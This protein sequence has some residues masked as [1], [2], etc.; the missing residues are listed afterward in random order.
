MP[1]LLLSN[2]ILSLDNIYFIKALTRVGN[3]QRVEMLRSSVDR[4]QKNSVAYKIMSPFQ[5]LA[6]VVSNCYNNVNPSGLGYG[7]Y[8]VHTKALQYRAQ[9]FG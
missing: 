7:I 1:T 6:V 4:E 8:L 2:S 3:N 5:G 9:V